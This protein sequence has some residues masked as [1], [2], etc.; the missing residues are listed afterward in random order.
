VDDAPGRLNDVFSSF[1][2]PHFGQATIEEQAKEL[3][4]SRSE[5]FELKCQA[6]L[7]VLKLNDVANCEQRV[8]QL[9]RALRL[10]ED[11]LARYR[12]QWEQMAVLA[13]EWKKAD[14]I[15]DETVRAMEHL[16][17]EYR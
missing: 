15:R 17:K 10:W 6:E 16:K 7:D 4:A 14:S 5:I 3:V 13:S 1:L 9:T 8:E 12:E 11:D 2:F